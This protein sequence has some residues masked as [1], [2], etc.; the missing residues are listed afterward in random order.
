MD[1]VHASPSERV[2]ASQATQTG[3]APAPEMGRNVPVSGK[4]FFL[5]RARYQENPISAFSMDTAEPP[6]NL[7]QAIR[8]VHVLP[9]TDPEAVA[10][11]EEALQQKEAALAEKEKEIENSKQK[12]VEN[13]LEVDDAS[14]IARRMAIKT[15]RRAV[16]TLAYAYLDTQIRLNVHGVNTKLS[17]QHDHFWNHFANGV[18]RFVSTPMRSLFGEGWGYF[19]GGMARDPSIPYEQARY[20]L[21]SIIAKKNSPEGAIIPVSIDGRISFGPKLTLTMIPFMA[22]G[23]FDNEVGEVIN[24]FDPKGNRPW[25]KEDGHWDWNDFFKTMAKNQTRVVLRNTLEDLTATVPYLWVRKFNANLLGNGL[26]NNANYKI[27]VEGVTH[28]SPIGTAQKNSIPGKDIRNKKGEYVFEHAYMQ[29]EFPDEK[30]VKSKVLQEDGTWKERKRPRRMF[31]YYR[32]HADIVKDHGEVGSLDTLNDRLESRAHAGFLPFGYDIHTGFVMYNIFTKWHRS[33]YDWAEKRIEGIM[34]HG[35]NNADGQGHS[36]N[37]TIA[38][39]LQELPDNFARLTFKKFIDMN[40]AAPFFY[41]QRHFADPNRFNVSPVTGAV[42][43]PGDFIGSVL[44]GT[45]DPTDRNVMTHV[46]LGR[47]V[48]ENIIWKDWNKNR[49]GEVLPNLRDSHTGAPIPRYN[50]FL[51][52]KFGNRWIWALSS[53][54]PYMVMKQETARIVERSPFFD[55]LYDGAKLGLGRLV[56]YYDQNITLNDMRAQRAERVNG[57]EC[58]YEEGSKSALSQSA[59]EKSVLEQATELVDKMWPREQWKPAQEHASYKQE[60]STQTT[61]NPKEKQTAPP[62][63][64][65]SYASRVTSPAVEHFQR[66]AF[67]PAGRQWA[68]A[69]HEPG[70]SSF[71]E[72]VEQVK[73]GMRDHKQASAEKFTERLATEEHVRSRS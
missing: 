64:T 30:Q 14:T 38:R 58:W 25:V 53:Y 59:E 26:D 45:R 40:M 54:T 9:L 2:Q 33:T 37:E 62:Q 36:L 73:S 52:H 18:D 7:G 19:D 61:D 51:P 10:K 16:G 35:W 72:R 39:D 5:N 24:I 46:G 6:E 69:N 23:F 67:T 49:N 44:Q 50:E 70:H 55:D 11:L 71:A 22:M 12:W 28:V 21:N 48:D 20:E 15:I 29:Q 27:Q 42:R 57:P 60:T 4:N 65:P 68:P 41:I 43:G 34:E 63:K 31:D 47:W 13:R 32:E 17:N 3:M 1:E 56:G 66:H 8:P